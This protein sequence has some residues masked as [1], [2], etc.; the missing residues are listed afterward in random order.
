MKYQIQ[1]RNVEAKVTKQNDVETIYTV[2]VDGE[3]KGKI[4]KSIFSDRKRYTGKMYGYDTKPSAKFRI[5][6]VDGNLSRSFYYMKSL[7]AAVEY[8]VSNY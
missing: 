2:F 7:K 5:A 4:E 8:M 3:E 6:E 1:N